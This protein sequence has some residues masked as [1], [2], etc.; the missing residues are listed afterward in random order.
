MENISSSSD[1][2]TLAFSPLVWAIHSNPYP[3]FTT[4]DPASAELQQFA[5]QGS[6]SAIADELQLEGGVSLVGIAQTTQNQQTVLRPGD[7]Y[8]FMIAADN[9]N[10]L[11]LVSSFLQ[12]NDLFISLP[13]TGLALFD[14]SGNP[15]SGDLTSSLTLFDAGTEVNEAPGT[16]ANQAIR[17]TT[18]EA[19][20]TENGVVAPVND[21]FS[22]P[23]VPSMLRLT[24]TPVEEVEK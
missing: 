8:T 4:G 22:Y 18:P 2:V 16:S 9:G 10:S 12:A 14:D 23:S 6:V 15:I 11:S 5:E 19:G 21:S 3:V 1:P 24:L 20:T 13:D 7:K 17:Q